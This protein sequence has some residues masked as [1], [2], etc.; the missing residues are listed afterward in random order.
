MKIC[1]VLPLF[2]ALSFL[3]FSAS[4]GSAQSDPAYPY[5]V[6]LTLDNRSITHDLNQQG[7]VPDTIRGTITDKSGLGADMTINITSA[8]QWVISTKING[9]VVYDGTM[10]VLGMDQT[11][12]VEI[13]I[14]PYAERP[15]T[16]TYCLDVSISPTYHLSGECV[17][18]TMTDVKASVSTDLPTP[19][20][21]V[22]PN[23]AGNYVTVR[24][25][26][27]SQLGYRYELFSITGAQV[28]QGMLSTNARI[29]VMLPADARINIEN[30]PSGAY[31]L[32][33]FDGNRTV[34][35][36]ALTVLH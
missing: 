13:V 30:L 11:L 25:L 19:D 17:T 5:S 22:V 33:L 26:K 3:L 1:T 31:R 20:I 28:R 32:L 18:L 9:N 21:A 8:K 29:N 35:N 27:D 15:D 4:I 2:F 36:T 14:S 23:P 34:A 16:E 7:E 12:P 6:D 10:M 24:G